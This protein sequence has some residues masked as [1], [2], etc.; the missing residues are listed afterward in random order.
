MLSR[1]LRR[2]VSFHLFGGIIPTVGEFSVWLQVVARE[3][4]AFLNED[5]S[6]DEFGQKRWVRNWSADVGSSGSKLGFL[7]SG[8]IAAVRKLYM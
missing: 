7:R 8:E 3:M 1:R 6:L 2:A 5:G 4:I